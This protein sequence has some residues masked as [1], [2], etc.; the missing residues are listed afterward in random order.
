MVLL[1]RTTHYYNVEWDYE[2]R[3]L[4]I[5]GITQKVNLLQNIPLEPGPVIFGNR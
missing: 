5:N 3:E 2:N 1:R 4:K